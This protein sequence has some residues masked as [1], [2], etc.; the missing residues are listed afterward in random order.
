M[1]LLQFVRFSLHRKQ[2]CRWQWKRFNR[3]LTLV[4]RIMME[5]PLS[6]NMRLRFRI[7]MLLDDCFDACFLVTQ[8]CLN[9]TCK[10][11]QLE[12]CGALWKRSN[13]HSGSNLKSVYI[14]IGEIDFGV[15]EFFVIVEYFSLY[16]LNSVAHVT[17]QK[18]KLC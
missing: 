6:N 7:T 17:S 14:V 18:I 2:T 4:C 3:S 15:S 13:V 8:R 11:S 5:Y 12:H 16:Q 9:R 1:K 10:V